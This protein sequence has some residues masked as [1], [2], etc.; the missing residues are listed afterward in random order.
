MHTIKEVTPIEVPAGKDE[1]FLK[2]WNAIA[3]RMR[4]AWGALSIQ[5]Y[6][7]LDPAAKFRFVAVSEWESTLHYEAATNHINR[8]FE[9]LRQT[10]PFA[11]YAASYRLVVSA[12]G[13]HRPYELFSR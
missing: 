1:E 8:A 7:S 9:D 2:G 12:A 5:L 4:H 11:A 10:M 6:E 3:E 13:A